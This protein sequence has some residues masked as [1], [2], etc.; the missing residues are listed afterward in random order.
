ML[1]YLT[2]QVAPLSK[3]MTEITVTNNNNFSIRIFISSCK[4]RRIELPQGNR[5]VIK[6]QQSTKVPVTYKSSQG[7]GKQNIRI[8]V[9]INE[10]HVF[11]VNM[12]VSVIPT[13]LILSR[14]KLEFSNDSML[15]WID[16]HNPAN[17]E[18]PFLWELNNKCFSVEPSYGVVPP[19]KTIA[20]LFNYVPHKDEPTMAEVMLSTDCGMQQNIVVTAVITAAKVALSSESLV[21]ENIPLNL[22]TKHTTV[23]RNFGYETVV[24]KVL[25]PEPLPGISVFPSKGTLYSFSDQIFQITVLLDKY[26]SFKCV[27]KIELQ[28]HQKV[29]FEVSGTVEYPNIVIRPNNLQMS[30]ISLG[31]V[32]KIK[33]YIENRGKSIVKLQFDFEDFS[34][35]FVSESMVS[36]AEAVSDEGVI[37]DPQQRKELWLHF[38]PID[39]GPHRF[40]L[41]IILNGKLGPP[42]KHKP[43]TVAVSTYLTEDLDISKPEEI[44]FLE[45][46]KTL[47]CVE[48]KNSA[49]TRILEFSERN[50]E[51]ASYHPDLKCSS[52]NTAKLKIT[53]ISNDTV[54]IRIRIDELQGPFYIKRLNLEEVQWVGNSYLFSLIPESSVTFAFAFIGYR[55]G[56]FNVCVPVFVK[57]FSEDK[58]FTYINLKGVCHFPKI[59][60]EETRICLLPV[61]ARVK[62]EKLVTFHMSHHLPKCQLILR[63]TN[64]NLCNDLQQYKETENGCTKRRILISYSSTNFSQFEATLIILCTCAGSSEIVINGGVENCSITNH[65]FLHM[66]MKLCCN[67]PVSSSTIGQVGSF[68]NRKIK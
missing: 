58:V 27:V 45:S 65:I 25:N 66:S 29:E 68:N 12:R 7:I 4:P 6:P 43:D 49:G 5:A 23:L 59:K 46:P 50:F 28:K 33:L 2:F 32:D 40:F 56:T 8:D 14:N 48:I 17:V 21:I 51:F 15:K 67:S 13:I 22:P 26:I 42:F 52:N 53:N 39:I 3:T 64:H 35:F 57:T 11:E 55:D 37:L 61:P 38:I 30:R 36:S 24:F 18:V 10:G 41:P 19:R 62:G 63:C 34:E 9:I 44:K 16:L 20:C 60:V 47:T 1:K 54:D 31:S